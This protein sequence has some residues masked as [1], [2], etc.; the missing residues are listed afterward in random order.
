MTDETPEASPQL[1]ARRI[2]GWLVLYGTEFRQTY[3]ELRAEVRKLNDEL[4]PEAYLQH[5]TVKLFAHVRRFVR[6]VVPGNPNAPEFALIGDLAHFRRGKGHVIPDRYRIFWVFSSQRK[7][8][9]FL[10]LNDASTL[11][12]EGS[13]TDSYEVFRRLLRQGRIGADFEANYRQ[14]LEVNPDLRQTN[15]RDVGTSKTET[16]P[17]E[18]QP[19]R[20]HRSRA[21]H[22][23]RD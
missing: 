4:T 18:R 3:D 23:R 16:D 9:I 19:R 12:K 10:Y 5:S 13:S 20:A 6:E 22:L 2:N 15:T 7:V 17:P 8:I 1:S 21:R 14:W 11:R